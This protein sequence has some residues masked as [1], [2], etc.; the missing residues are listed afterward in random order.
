MVHHRPGRIR[1]RISLASSLARGRDESFLTEDELRPLRRP[2][3]GK[4]AASITPAEEAASHAAWARARLHQKFRGAVSW[5][6]ATGLGLYGA[7][8]LMLLGRHVP[9]GPAEGVTPPEAGPVPLADHAPIDPAVHL[10]AA[11]A[12]AGAG[13]AAVIAAVA[14]GGTGSLGLPPGLHGAS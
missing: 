5:T 4:P 7:L 12:P 3:P 14:A 13:D 9:D 2:K 6:E 11:E 10:A 1:F 8:L